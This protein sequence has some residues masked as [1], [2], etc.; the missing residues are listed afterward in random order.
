MELKNID[1]QDKPLFDDALRAFPPS[2]SEH[3]FTNLFAWRNAHP[4]LFCEMRGSILLLARY[5]DGYTIYGPPIGAIGC[6]EAIDAIAPKLD[7]PLLAVERVP[8]DRAG[9]LAGAEEDRDSFDY[10]YL[11]EDL[12]ELAGRRYHGKRNLIVQCTSENDC[13]YERLDGRTA[14]EAIGMIERWCAE[15]ECGKD[16]GLCH[17]Y[18]AVIEALDNFDALGLMGGA[19]RIGGRIEAFTAAEALSPTTAVIHFEK[20]MPKFKGLYQV[21]NNW[22]CKNDLGRF[23]FV[24]REQDLGI[25]GLRR[26]K[27]SYYPHHFVKKAHSL[28]PA[29]NGRL[30]AFELALCH[31]P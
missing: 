10:V 13:T 16:H 23:E 25:E 17:E 3:T 28:T 29:A 9:G 18:H 11:R 19:I 12:A 15:R 6:A 31:E 22:F 30:P 27:E 14:R 2:I 8:P 7:M 5:K 26:A 21:I 1:I 4:V 20:A 24:N